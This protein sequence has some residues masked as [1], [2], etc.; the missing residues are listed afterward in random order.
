ML[1]NKAFP[2]YKSEE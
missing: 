2:V 1:A